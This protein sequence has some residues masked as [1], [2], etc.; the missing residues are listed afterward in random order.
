MSNPRPDLGGSWVQAMAE[1]REKRKDAEPL[2]V[3]K[4]ASATRRL[5]S[6]MSSKRIP[7]ELAAEVCTLIESAYSSFEPLETLSHFSGFA[8]SA[9]SGDTTTFFDRSPIQGSANPLAP[10]LVIDHYSDQDGKVTITASATFSAAYEGP[11]GCVHGGYIAAVFDEVLGSAQ[12]LSGNPGMTANLSVNYRR[13]TPLFEEITYEAELVSVVG[14]KIM[15]AG[16]SFFDGKV[17][18]E[19]TGLFIS[20]DFEKLA[21]LAVEKLSR[22]ENPN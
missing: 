11:P 6:L 12:S 15:T 18:A 5:I 3:H 16:R 1:L 17:T 13:P 9:N 14:R 19:A 2:E 21:Q 10:P 4:L 8:E 22:A 7:P 20:V